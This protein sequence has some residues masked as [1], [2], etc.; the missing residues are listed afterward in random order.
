MF[1]LYI[2]VLKDSPK[3]CSFTNTSVFHIDS[4]SEH[5]SDS[6]EQLPNIGA[7]DHVGPK[8]DTETNPSAPSWSLSYWVIALC[9]VGA[10]VIVGLLVAIFGVMVSIR[11]EQRNR[12]KELKKNE[13]IYSPFHKDK[14]LN[15]SV[16]V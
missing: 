3:T 12:A 9:I 5:K 10:L 15:T 11:R 16:E 4:T 13:R 7:N 2:S 8:P 14:N 6:S 1:N